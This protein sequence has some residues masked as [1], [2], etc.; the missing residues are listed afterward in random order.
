[1]ENSSIPTSRENRKV[2]PVTATLCLLLDRP[3]AVSLVPSVAS[4]RPH[5]KL[6]YSEAKPQQ[7][8]ASSVNT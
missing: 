5:P 6:D 2:P 7:H 1:M 8:I 4:A 3:Y